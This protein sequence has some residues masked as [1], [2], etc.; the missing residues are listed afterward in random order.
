[1]LFRLR[2]ER[3]QRHLCLDCGGGF[4]VL[5][6]SWFWLPPLSLERWRWFLWRHRFWQSPRTFPGLLRCGPLVVC[7]WRYETHGRRSSDQAAIRFGGNR[8][9]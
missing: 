9:H 2:H 4:A 8:G 1:M 6:L 7:W 3:Q 5:L